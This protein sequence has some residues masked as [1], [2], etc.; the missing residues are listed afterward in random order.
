MVA[1][2]EPVGLVK[3]RLYRPFPGR[4]TGRRPAADGAD[5]RRARPDQGT[6]RAG[7]APV[8]RRRR[9]HR[10]GVRRGR[11]DEL[12]FAA[13][14]RVIRRPLRAGV[15]GVHPGHGQGRAR[16]ARPRPAQTALHRRHLRRRD[17][18]QPRA[19]TADFSV[20][21]PD[22]EVQAMF[23]GLGADGTVGANKASV[24]IIGEST[25]L[26][27][28][29]YFVYDSKKSG[30]VTVSH[31]RFGPEPIRSTYLVEEADFVACHQFGLLERMPVLDRRQAGRHLPAQQPVR[32]RD[33]VG[34]AS[35]R[36]A[37]ADH[38]QGDRR[39]GGRRLRRSPRTSAWATAS[40]RSCS[41]ASSGSPGVLPARRGDRE[42]QAVG[43]EVLRQP[44]AGHR[45]S[46]LR[47]HR[48]LARRTR[49]CGRAGAGHRDPIDGVHRS[50]RRPRTSSSG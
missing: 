13:R 36:G 5:A 18:P 31:L 24:K 33:G 34:P 44:G 30:S 40:T 49:P 26:W 29:G 28:Q 50:P 19:T 12:P 1:A 37:A 48:P 46:E 45:R 4:A 2:G 39:L 11:G 38:R 8:P 32:D 9:R 20:P 42:D 41:R 16:R 14:P 25:D 15:Q 3:V 27:A 17:P 43:G 22:G 23:F 10:R 35:S 47:R 7:R 6:R 21:R